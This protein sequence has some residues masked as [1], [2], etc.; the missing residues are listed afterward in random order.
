[1]TAVEESLEESV[2]LVTISEELERGVMIDP[3]A[4]VRRLGGSGVGGGGGSSSLEHDHVYQTVKYDFYLGTK[5]NVWERYPG[6]VSRSGLSD[7]RLHEGLF[8][9]MCCHTK[10]YEMLCSGGTG[11][12]L[13]A[14]IEK[15]GD[16]AFLSAMFSDSALAGSACTFT[17][18]MDRM[19][20]QF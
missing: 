1:M 11:N 7:V 20:R 17:F 18:T 10:A 6:G 3:V 14:K 13:M 15:D 19:E 12:T 4:R 2:P 16:R 5:A 9:T 8:F